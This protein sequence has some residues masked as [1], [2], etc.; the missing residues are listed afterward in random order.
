VFIRQADFLSGLSHASMSLGRMRYRK[1]VKF[2]GPHVQP[3]TMVTV[4]PV[5]SSATIAR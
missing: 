5:I 1:S 4:N 3:S 2:V